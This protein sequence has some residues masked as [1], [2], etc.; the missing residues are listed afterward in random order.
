M[1]R[2]ISLGKLRSK[3]QEA[4]LVE[5]HVR[6]LAKE[7]EREEGRQVLKATA[8]A[9][10]KAGWAKSTAS[11]STTSKA[12]AIVA[13]STAASSMI[14]AHDRWDMELEGD[15]AQV[16]EEVGV[17]VPSAQAVFN[18]EEELG[19]PDVVEELPE[20]AAKK[21]KGGGKRLAERIKALIGKTDK[22]SI[23]ELAVLRW[24][25]GGGAKKGKQRR[26]EYGMARLLA[27]PP[28]N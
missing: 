4:E 12:K 24:R 28:G 21:K 23:A 1:S 2:A 16:V 9:K 25:R 8:R 26:N 15:Q 27:S 18:P 6:R 20:E 3:A 19:P 22:D 5:H 17:A 11:S 13:R 10:T 14:P 7:K